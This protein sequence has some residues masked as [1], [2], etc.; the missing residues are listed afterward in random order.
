MTNM[1]YNYLIR[2][3]LHITFLEE[4]LTMFL[5]L[6]M[7][8]TFVKVFLTIFLLLSMHITFEKDFLT[9]FLLLSM[10]ITFP[11]L[12]FQKGKGR[13]IDGVDNRHVHMA[14]T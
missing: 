9:T 3:S 5:L 8:V 11:L 6:S 10:H 12:T 14:S 7:H 4:I 1:S 13:P 2:L